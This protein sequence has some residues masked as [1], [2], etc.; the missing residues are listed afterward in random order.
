MCYM[1][2]R[3]ACVSGTSTEHSAL[4]RHVYIL[5]Y[6]FC[7]RAAVNPFDIETPSPHDLSNIK[8]KSCNTTGNEKCVNNFFLRMSL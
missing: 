5:F 7:E 1:Q 3:Y 8:K 6:T 4:M 2:A